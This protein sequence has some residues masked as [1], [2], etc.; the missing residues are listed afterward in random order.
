MKRVIVID[1]AHLKG[2]YGGCLLTA[3]AQDPNF[4][5]Y[6]LAFGWSIARTTTRGS[7][8]SAFWAWLSPMER[9]WHS[10]L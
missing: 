8:F 1:G 7:G 6:P 10:S 5:V 9:T 2:K 4:Q 3:S